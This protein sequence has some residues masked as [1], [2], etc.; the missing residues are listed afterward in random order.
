M[1]ESLT[2][3]LFRVVT[4]YEGSDGDATKKLYAELEAI[5]PIGTIAIDLFR[6]QKASSRA[7]LYRGGVRGK[8]SYRG[9]AYE[10]KQWAMSNLTNALTKH[11]EFCGLTWGWGEDKVQEY[12]RW[13][14]YIDLP[15]GQVSY[16]TDAR[17]AGPDYH[18]K[19]DGERDVAAARI[20]RY[21]AFLLTHQ[22]V[23]A[24]QA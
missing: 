7:K 17:G 20:C 6:A 10:R 1:P 23:E 11:A 16:H 15:N 5:G 13:V 22:P 9:M 19:W 24:T 2:E 8:G 14:L 12:H 18:G 21:V 3:T 4:I